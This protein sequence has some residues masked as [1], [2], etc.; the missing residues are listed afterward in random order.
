MRLLIIEDNQDLAI[1]LLEYFS[2]HDHVVDTAGDGLTGLHLAVVN[3]YDAII[4]DIM[5]PGMDGLKLC[6]KLREQAGKTTPILILTAR[7]TL[8]DKIIGL[9]AGADDYMVKPFALREVEAR[10]R[11]IV[12]RTQPQGVLPVLTVGD[13]IFDTTTF[14][15]TRADQRIELPPI[16]LKLLELLMRRS[17][18]VVTKSEMEAAI[19]GDDPPDSD[20][21]KTHLHVLRNAIDKPYTRD[22]LHTVRGIGYRLVADSAPLS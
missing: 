4:L 7:D 11:S 13:L 18:K 5:L 10:L 19:W 20:V 6:R 14:L 12:R 8:D 16:P 3:E 2:E 1:S 9:D 15:V 17:P 22:L 21:L